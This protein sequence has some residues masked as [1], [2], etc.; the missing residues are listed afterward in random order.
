M[1]IIEKSSSVF[2][3]WLDKKALV[4]GDVIKIVSEASEQPN[5]QGDGTQ[6]VVKVLVKGKSK[7]PENFSI[8]T[9]SR[10]AL[11]DAFGKDT[12]EWV[13][14]VLNIAVEKVIVAG[15]RGIAVYLIPEGMVMKENADG[16]VY[17][18]HPESESGKV[19]ESKGG[20]E[21][22]DYPEEEINAE[23]IPF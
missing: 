17:V 14:K 6:L 1:T 11:I 13:D 10:N 12:K 2:G 15:K 4:N 5:R 16:F 7:E 20:S 18:G 21:P 9:Q 19:K 22:V 3:K 8:N 23:D